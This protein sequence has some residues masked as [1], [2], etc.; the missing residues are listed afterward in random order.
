MG[1]EFKPLNGWLCV[2]CKFLVQSLVTRKVRVTCYKALETWTEV[3]VHISLASWLLGWWHLDSYELTNQ[4]QYKATILVTWFLKKYF[5]HCLSHEFLSNLLCSLG[6]S[7]YFIPGTISDSFRISKSA[8]RSQ[9]MYS[10][11]LLELCGST[12]INL[13]L[14]CLKMMQLSKIMSYYKLC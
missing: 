2:S 14:G 8:L 6:S 4:K 5:F 13:I 11:A 9:Y 7:A 1:A 10:I 12:H 3:Y